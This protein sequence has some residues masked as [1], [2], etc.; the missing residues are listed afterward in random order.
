M[1]NFAIA[2][3]REENSRVI[4]SYS[5][6]VS[7]ELIIVTFVVFK[8]RIYIEI[9]MTFLDLKFIGAKEQAPNS[10]SSLVE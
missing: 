8:I 9:E 5:P 1:C 4:S 7:I 6:F 3:D 10:K 2:H